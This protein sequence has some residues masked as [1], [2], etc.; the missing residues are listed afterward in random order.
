MKINRRTVLHTM[1]IF[2]AAVFIT[3]SF[4]GVCSALSTKDIKLGKWSEFWKAAKKDFEQETNA[5]KPSGTFL[6]IRKGTGIDSQAKKIDK[7]Y[8]KMSDAAMAYRAKLLETAPTGEKQKKKRLKEL[9]KL[10]K[11]FKK[12]TTSFE[13]KVPAFGAKAAKYVGLLK[14]RI[15]KEKKGSA[16][17]KELKLLKKRLKA[18]EGQMDGASG[19]VEN[20]VMVAKIK[21]ENPEDTGK[22]RR[23]KQVK[24][25]DPTKFQKACDGAIKKARVWGAEMKKKLKKGLT[26]KET[27]KGTTLADLFNSGVFDAARDNTQP[28][29]NTSLQKNKSPTARS[30][31]RNLYKAIFSNNITL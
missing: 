4:A 12:A 23:K 5:K 25:M 10:E 14:D 2:T 15:K 22:E 6:K 29:K 13:K 9:K 28:L 7:A 8:K 16:L 11:A 31:P 17:K 30:P 19:S 20:L 21:M 27:E 1:A 3:I 26:E 24:A 18:I